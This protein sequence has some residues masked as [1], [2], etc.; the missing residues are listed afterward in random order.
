MIWNM[1][2]LLFTDPV[3]VLTLVGKFVGATS[4][5]AP[6]VGGAI[7]GGTLCGLAGTGFLIGRKYF[8]PGQCNCADCL[9]ALTDIPVEEFKSKDLKRYWEDG[10]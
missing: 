8:W 3:A 10:V 9:A 2:S 6:V 7:T 1:V 5:I 4:H